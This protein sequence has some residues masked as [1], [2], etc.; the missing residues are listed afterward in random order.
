MDGGL[1]ENRIYQVAGK[2]DSEPLFPEDPFMAA[3]RR[4]S[5]VLLREAPVLPPSRNR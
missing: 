2:A 1:K 4:I 5:I 3:N